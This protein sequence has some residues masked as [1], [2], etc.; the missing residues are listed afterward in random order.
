MQFSKKFPRP[1]PPNTKNTDG[2]YN[3]FT[4][5]ILLVLHGMLGYNSKMLAMPNDKTVD[6]LTGKGN[7]NYDLALLNQGFG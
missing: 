4:F 3:H 7:I 6:C 1:H 2:V 5:R